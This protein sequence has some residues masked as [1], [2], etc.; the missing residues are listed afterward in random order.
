MKRVLDKRGSHDVAHLPT[1]QTWPQLLHHLLCNHI[2]L[3][4][5]DFVNTGKAEVAAA[6][7]QCQQKADSGPSEGVGADSQ[8]IVFQGGSAT[9]MIPL[10]VTRRE[11]SQHDP[12]E[13]RTQESRTQGNGPQTKDSVDA[14]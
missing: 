14:E 7:R 2:P 9:G 6:T 1:V 4:H 3:F 8:H 5:I 12:R 13:S 10:N 11:P